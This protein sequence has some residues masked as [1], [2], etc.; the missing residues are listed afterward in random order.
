MSEHVAVIT[1]KNSGPNFGKGHYSREHTWH[2]DGGVTV[3]ASASPLVVPQPWSSASA[4]DPEEAYV[5]SVSSCHMLWWL[6]IAAKHGFTVKT[7][8]DRA[9]GVMT[10]NEVGKLWVSC[11]TLNPTATYEGK[12]PSVDEEAHLHHLAHEECF[13][14][15]SIK[16]EVRIG[17]RG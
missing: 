14:A 11:I 17:T 6:S 15:Q 2:F 10:R 7:Y 8:A 4:V 13:I 3:P 16:T 9:V 12:V 1:W 5:A